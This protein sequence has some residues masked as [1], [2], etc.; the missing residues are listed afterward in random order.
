[1]YFKVDNIYHIY[2]RGNNKDKI[3]F[4]EK[5][6]LFFIKKTRKELSDHFHFLAYCLMPNHFHFLVQV[7]ENHN[8][9]DDFKSSD[10]LFQPILLS[11]KNYSKEISNKIAVLLR[12]YTRAINIQE[13]RTGSL[14]QQK[15][16]SKC[17]N[18]LNT[19]ENNYISTCFHYIYQN[20]LN[21]GLVNKLENWEYSSFI[22]YVELRHNP[23]CNIELASQLVNIDRNNFIE[24][25]YAVLEEVGMKGIWI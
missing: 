17:L 24:Q 18:E 1:M 3:F 12:S 15:T 25:S 22:E 14:F 2:N 9:S 7:K 4:E 13:G 6:Y 20:P 8:S 21:A 23:L 19:S 11:E 5:N 16:K 10:E